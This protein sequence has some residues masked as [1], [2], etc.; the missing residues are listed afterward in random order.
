VVDLFLSE[1][2]RL[3]ENKDNGEVQELLSKSSSSLTTAS[4]PQSATMS[5]EG[6]QC[7]RNAI[8]S[9]NVACDWEFSSGCV[10]IKVQYS[11]IGGSTWRDG[12]MLCLRCVSAGTQCNLYGAQEQPFECFEFVDEPS[13]AVQIRLPNY[14]GRFEVVYITPCHGASSTYRLRGRSEVVDVPSSVFAHHP[15]VLPPVDRKRVMV[16]RRRG[17]GPLNTEQ[18][19]LVVGAHVAEYLQGINVINVHW[20]IRS[21]RG[22]LVTDI[23]RYNVWIFQDER[24]CNQQRGATLVVEFDVVVDCGGHESTRGTSYVCLRLECL[25]C[26]DVDFSRCRCDVDESNRISLRIQLLKGLELPN[27]SSV[28][29]LVAAN[30]SGKVEELGVYCKFCSAE[31][32]KPSALHKLECLPSGQFDNVNNT[33]LLV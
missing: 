3:L 18:N 26:E 6:L 23:F 11:S 15:D 25:D 13:A 27:E 10:S 29:R 9:V 20:N 12:D 8:Q 24:I 31:F 7:D 33:A 22:G 17:T 21:L 16:Q 4:L 1:A 19:G 28:T 32:I 14:G 2:R 30:D 5:I